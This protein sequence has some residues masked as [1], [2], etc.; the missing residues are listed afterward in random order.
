MGKEQQRPFIFQVSLQAIIGSRPRPP[1]EAE[2]LAGD[3]LTEQAARNF[4][5]R[6]ANLLRTA[7]PF[8][9]LGGI[10]QQNDAR[11]FFAERV[12]AY[13]F[14]GLFPT[15]N[16]RPLNGKRNR[17]DSEVAA[18]IHQRLPIPLQALPDQSPLDV[19]G[20]R[21]LDH[22]AQAVYRTYESDLYRRNVRDQLAND[23]LFAI[24]YGPNMP[25]S[26]ITPPDVKAEIQ[27]TLSRFSNRQRTTRRKS[28]S[29]K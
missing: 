16:N 22:A 17:V 6:V 28:R 14:E 21:T 7:G 12:T 15:G 1:T 10:F 8:K 24:T 25:F 27:K 26:Y 11:V 13:F 18:Y 2:K 29:L 3:I 9:P 4:H 19:A 23:L 5:N 20:E